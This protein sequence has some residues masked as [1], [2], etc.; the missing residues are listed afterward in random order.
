MIIRNK[1][2]S[3]TDRQHYFIYLLKNITVCEEDVPE[4]QHASDIKRQIVIY[5]HKIMISN[6]CKSYHF[7]NDTAHKKTAKSL[8]YIALYF[9]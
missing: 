9:T 8:L 1:R 3:C 6:M 2:L 7:Q 4:V 5:V